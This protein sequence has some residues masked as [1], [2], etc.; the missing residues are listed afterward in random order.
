MERL[1]TVRAANAL[2]LIT[3]GLILTLGMAMQLG[4]M[5]IGVIGTELFLI[6]LPAIL[7]L[8]W[9]RLPVRETLRLRWPGSTLAAFS[10]LI[11]A[12][13]FIMAIGMDPWME[14][15]FGYTVPMPPNIFPTTPAGI[16]SCFVALAVMAPLCEE[17]LFRGIIQRA[18]ERRSPA[19]GI[20]VGGTLFAFWHMRFQGLLPLFPVSMALGYV[21]WRSNSLIAGMLLHAS[22]NAVAAGYLITT[23]TR[24]DLAPDVSPVAAVA[25]G[26]ALAGAGLWLFHRA[27]RA[28]GAPTTPAESTGPPPPAFSPWRAAI[29]V[30]PLCIAA[31]VYTL[32][33]GGEAFIGRYPEVLALGKRPSV[34]PA[35]LKAPGQWR[36]EVRN[37]QGEPA[38]EAVVSLNEDGDALILEYNLKFSAWNANPNGDSHDAIQ[39][40]HHQSTRWD[41]ES[42]ELRGLEA[43]VHGGGREQSVS[44]TRDGQDLKL[45]IRWDQSPP[46]ETSVPSHALLAGEWPWR[47]SALPLTLLYARNVSLVAAGHGEAA[48]TDGE[49]P[50]AP[51]REFRFRAA[52]EET[53]LVVRRAEPVA[54]PAGNFI[55][56]VV[57]AGGDETAWYDIESPHTVLRYDSGDLSYLLTAED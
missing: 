20:L 2:Y 34:T 16:I 33:A 37:S 35:N 6:L 44:A 14:A 38:G 45:S 3:M 42:A 43:T 25:T 30:I 56:W 55:A 26:A 1:P 51:G 29:T 13:L 22:A 40:T 27:S 5:W 50:A 21:V 49:I 9:T 18:Y 41:K 54:T 39:V 46:E 8:R 15:L 48:V 31:L 23:S 47:M 57:T 4:A 52:A 10:V 53:H 24:P 36:Y 12:G 11:G 32:A 17:V 28:T 7:Y 19:A